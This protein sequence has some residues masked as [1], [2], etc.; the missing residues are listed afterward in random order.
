MTIEVP[1]G[2]HLVIELTNADDQVHDL[3]VFNGYANQYQHDPLVARVGERVRV[4]TL[5][6]GP[7]WF[8]RTGLFR[9]RELPLRHPRH[10]GCRAGSIRNLPGEG[11]AGVRSGEVLADRFPARILAG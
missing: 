1:A 6:A 3:V 9:A 4:W 10:V 7:R 8:R 2:D 5:D 11:I